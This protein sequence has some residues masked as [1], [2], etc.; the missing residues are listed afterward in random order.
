[1]PRVGLRDPEEARV[2]L[3]CKPD[4]GGPRPALGVRRGEDEVLDRVDDL[5]GGC[6]MVGHAC[7]SIRTRSPGAGETG[8]GRG[9]RTP[10][11][12][13][14]SGALAAAHPPVARGPATR[15]PSPGP[16]V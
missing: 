14:R 5:P 15:A 13:R 6:G 10:R 16:A 1:M 11:R 12:W 4:R 8:A 7:R 2:V 3:V 9:R